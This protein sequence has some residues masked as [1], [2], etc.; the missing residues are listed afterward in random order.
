MAP[1]AKH[2]NSESRGA[3]DSAQSFAVKIAGLC[4]LAQTIAARPRYCGRRHARCSPLSLTPQRLFCNGTECLPRLFIIGASKCASSSLHP[5]VAGARS[6]TALCG[7]H[8]AGNTNGYDVIRN[9][10]IRVQHCTSQRGGSHEV[11]PGLYDSTQAFVNAEHALQTE[12][13]DTPALSGQSS[14]VLHLEMSNVNFESQRQLSVSAPDNTGDQ[15][16][17]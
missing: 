6:I 16:I 1:S 4:A 9:T 11:E 3:Q 14:A 2:I 5:Q 12:L 7:L 15:V 13:H 17:R 8:Y 10:T